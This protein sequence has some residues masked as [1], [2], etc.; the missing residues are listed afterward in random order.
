MLHLVGATLTVLATLGVVLKI[1]E[2]LSEKEEDERRRQAEQQHEKWVKQIEKESQLEEKRVREASQRRRVQK[3]AEIKR[4]LYGIPVELPSPPAKRQWWKF[5][6]STI[7]PLATPTEPIY[8]EDEAE[9]KAQ[10]EFRVK[11]PFVCVKVPSKHMSEFLQ[12]FTWLE[13]KTGSVPSIEDQRKILIGIIKS[14]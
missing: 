2:Y 13:S 5:G 3:E 11:H 4:I 10:E 1:G 12:E 14:S 9:L 6:K 7:E 8:S